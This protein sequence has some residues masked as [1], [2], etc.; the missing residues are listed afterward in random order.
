MHSRQASTPDA[1]S[2]TPRIIFNSDGDFSMRAHKPYQNLDE[3]CRGIDELRGTQVDVYNYS[4]SAGGDVFKYP[5]AIAPIVGDDLDDLD[6]VPAS[7][8]TEVENLKGFAAAGLDPVAVMAQHA[9]E[10]GMRFWIS[11]RMNDTHDDVHECAALHGSFRKAHPEWLIGSP[12]PEPRELGNPETGFSWALDYAQPAVRERQLA[13]IEELVSNYDVEGIELDF[14]RGPYYFKTAER[15]RGMPLLTDF[16]RSA[17]RVV[18]GIAERKGRPVTIAVRLDRTMEACRAK[19]IDAPTWIEEELADYFIPMHPGRLDMG[20]DVASFAE[21]ARD[22]SCQIIGGL[23]GAAYGYGHLADHESGPWRHP[24]V[25]MMRAAAMGYYAQ[26][27][28]GVYLFNFD[29]H[30]FRGAYAPYSAE[31]MQMLHEIGLPATIAG[32]NTRYAVTVD[33]HTPLHRRDGKSA[34]SPPHDAVTRRARATFHYLCGRRRGGR[35]SG[36]PA[37]CLPIAP[38]RRWLSGPGR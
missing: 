34:T 19:G 35:R 11:L 27:A 3:F 33:Q 16:V 6:S 2:T 20:A 28:A 10:A 15:E 12:Y 1:K 13:I 8:R 5:S 17:C 31:E 22:T 21:A 29:C 4:V 18:A 32:K 37:H 26:G 9:H 24:T 14:L 38:H 30:R 36:R 25:E 23:D 7:L